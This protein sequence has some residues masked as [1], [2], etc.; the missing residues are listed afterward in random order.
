MSGR[1]PNLNHVNFA[2]PYGHAVAVIG[3]S[4]SG[5]STALNLLMR[6]YDPCEGRILVDGQNIQRVSLASLRSQMAV[7]FQETFLFNTT[8]R[9]NIRMGKL[10]ASDAEVDAAA[11]AAGGARYDSQPAGGVRH[12][13]GSKAKPFRGAS[14]SALPSPAPCSVVPPSCCWTRRPPRSTLKR[15]GGFMTR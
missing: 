13:P 5:K 7:V 4:G 2:I 3:R 12:G 6:F 1:Q 8:L 14:A 10:D 9:E 15:K 11:K